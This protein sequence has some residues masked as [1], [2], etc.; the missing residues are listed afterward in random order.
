MK[1]KDEVVKVKGR[2]LRSLTREKSKVG[3]RLYSGLIKD[4]KE[5][6]VEGRCN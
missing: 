6:L 2:R 5:E 4:L 1:L 3:N